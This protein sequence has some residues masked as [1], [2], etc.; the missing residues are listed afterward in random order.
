MLN[1]AH[2]KEWSVSGVLAL[3]VTG[4]VALA[5][6]APYWIAIPEKNM[7][8]ITQG[9]TTLWAGWLLILGFYF[10]TTNSQGRKDATIQTLATTAS[11]AQDALAPLSGNAVDTIP[12]APGE[13]VTVKATGE[14][15]I[16]G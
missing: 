16:D 14:E 5:A 10:G 9:Q 4:M 2:N 7:N 8:L 1:E 13:Q 3:L 6:L 15:I 12:V 11:K